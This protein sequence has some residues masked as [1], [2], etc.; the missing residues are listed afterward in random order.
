MAKQATGMIAQGL[1]ALTL[2]T[3]FYPIHWMVQCLP[4]RWALKLGALLGHLHARFIPDQ[5]TCQIRAGIKSG[6][7]N[8]VSRAK[9][10]C[11]VRLNLVTRYKH[12]IDGFF[13]Q[14]LDERLIERMVPVIDNK[15]YLDE[16]LNGGKGAILLVS[17]FGSFGMLIGGLALRGYRLRQ[18]FT[19]TP[20]PLYR[21]WHWVEH[22]I[23]QVKLRCWTHESVDFEFWRP[24]KYLRPLYR[25]LMEGEILVLYGDGARG[26][27]F[28]SVDFMGRPLLLSVGPFRIAAR[29]EVALIPAFILR[30]ADDC[31]RIV[32]EKP[33]VLQA[34]DSASILQAANQY[35]ALLAHYVR[36][37][38]DH[39]F[40]WARL[41][42]G[43]ENDRLVLELM[44]GNVDDDDFYT[45]EKPQEA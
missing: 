36:T 19:L 39:W 43:Q 11:I 20:Q 33:I 6:W 40:T 42:Q 13:Y 5:L 44:S 32:L 27:Q 37:Y 23:M 3:F 8:E 4:W 1:K 34:D 15:A 14:Y 35:A 7:P 31:H 29:A 26:R 2:L 17:H 21:T 12:L 18:I 16:A 30:Q 41:R 22:A 38:P 28:V 9:L 24:G 10:E 25:K 45:A